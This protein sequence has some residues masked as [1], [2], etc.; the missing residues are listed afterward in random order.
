MHLWTIHFHARRALATSYHFGS[1]VS[2]SIS[3]LDKSEIGMA[4]MQETR[5]MGCKGFKLADYSPLTS[6]AATGVVIGVWLLSLGSPFLLL[7]AVSYGCHL[8]TIGN[9]HGS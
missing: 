5:M 7:L 2:L 6:A 8:M 3:L 1:E 9:G 4:T